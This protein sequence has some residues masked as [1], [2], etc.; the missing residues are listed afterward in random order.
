MT[1]QH[2]VDLVN[3]G[4]KEGESALHLA[5]DLTSDCAHYNRE[6]VK[7]MKLLLDYHADLFLESHVTKETPLHYCAR[8]GNASTLSVVLEYLTAVS[9]HTYEQNQTQKKSGNK[10]EAANDV[11]K[12]SVNATQLRSLNI[13]N[14]AGWS[15]LMVASES[16]HGE[17]VEMLLNHNVRVD[18]FDE[19]G[20]TALHYACARG[21][22]EIADELM[23]H[24]AF[25]NARTRLGVTPLH[26]SAQYGHARLS[27]LLINS[28]NATVDI[29]SLTRKTPMHLA[30]QEGQIDVCQALLDLN[31]DPFAKDME[32]QT[33]LHL[34][35]EKDFS[36][37]VKLFLSYNQDLVNVCNSEGRTC[38]HIAASK[39]SMSVIKGLVKFNPE[40]LVLDK[41]SVSGNTTLHLAAS[42]GFQDIVSLLLDN[43]ANALEEND[44][45]LT[46]LHLAAIF[47]HTNVLEVF[48]G[49]QVSLNY[50]SRESGLTAIHM[51]AHYG[52]TEFVQ[53]LLQD[54]GAQAA[55][56]PPAGLPPA[57]SIGHSDLGGGG[58]QGGGDGGL[59]GGAGMESEGIEYGFTPLHLAAESGWENLVRLLLNSPGVQPD[60][61]T[62]LHGTT[63]LHLAA[64]AGHSNV[65]GLLLSKHEGLLSVYDGRDRSAL[66]MAAA[67]GHRDLC[68]LLV[69]QGADV[70]KK[71]V[72]GWTPLHFAAKA[73]HLDTVEALMENGASGLLETK[74]HKQPICYA[75]AQSHY[76]VLIYLL[77][78]EHNSH[79]LVKDSRF[80]FDMIQCSDSAEDP[81]KVVRYFILWSPAPLEIALKLSAS[82]AEQSVQRKD[83]AKEF[84]LASSFCQTMGVDLTSVTTSIV[85][86]EDVA[87]SLDLHGSSLLDIMIECEQKE[88]VAHA[89]VQKYLSDLWMGHYT[90]APWMI[91]MLLVASLLPPVFFLLSLPIR[92]F[93]L[94]RI[95]LLKMLLY[96]ISHLYFIA[97]LSLTIAFKLDWRTTQDN[98]LIPRWNEW[99]L[100]LFICGLALS[101]I[102]Q[103]S[104][105]NGLSSLKIVV[106]LLGCI[107][108]LIHAAAFAISDY[109]GQ[110]D[111]IYIRNQVLGC[112]LLCCFA[113]L[114]DFL[115]FHHMFGPWAIIISD[116]MKDLFRFMILMGLFILGFT[117]QVS[118]IR[119]PAYPEDFCTSIGRHPLKNPS[120]GQNNTYY[121][122]GR[123][124]VEDF[125]RMAFTLFGLVDYAE[126]IEET[127]CIPIWAETWSFYVYALYNVIALI[128]LINLLIA[129]MSDTYQRIEQQSDIEWKFGR[130]ILIRTMSGKSPAA[131][132][133]NVLVAIFMLIYG[134][135]KHRGKMCSV[136]ELMRDD[137]AGARKGEESGWD[138]AEMGQ[139]GD[140]ATVV[141]AGSG[142]GGGAGALDQEVLSNHTN[143]SIKSRAVGAGGSVGRGTMGK[144]KH[145]GKR[146][147]DDEHYK[148]AVRVEN[149]VDWDVVMNMYKDMQH[150][151]DDALEDNRHQTDHKNYDLGGS[152]SATRAID[153]SFDIQL[154][155]WKT[156]AAASSSEV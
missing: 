128:V 78:R 64:Q 156:A 58:N 147:S 80:I 139:G 35:A 75:A 37:V 143:G 31:A 142:T 70:N 115:T 68:V 63:P 105:L 49:A 84:F 52:Q 60:V 44:E 81:Y 102:L 136:R 149:V 65:I 77:K 3:C 34:A 4:N 39:G 121:V 111:M 15:P 90:V 108:I 19:G 67:N 113:Q 10:G 151:D 50:C 57:Y 126:L 117:L 152:F 14:K 119:Q 85:D 103:P 46:P 42:G 30:A 55:S 66:H 7:L 145:R 6:E 74:D 91:F 23:W 62:S 27:Q 17:V 16:G 101:E 93:T 104:S 43:G 106:I 56:S 71:D 76:E 54:V 9:V 32:E 132:P 5:A 89:S 141:T 155:T 2:A 96:I 116:L 22:T 12:K 120:T 107:S 92:R 125:T 61:H 94:N 110:Y 97:L 135:I 13:R 83:R 40:G 24:K 112:V 41:D 29:L 72:N 79:T 33:P 26:L 154:P 133:V 73:G 47:G 134:L 28:H 8:G 88:V 150:M 129:M 100:V 109:E 122:G 82:Y 140:T 124:V 114:L 11:R 1:T 127:V 153:N 118:T 95:P 87:N 86:T 138:K 137:S 48:K 99:L 18:L 130:A 25:V 69:G 53:E 51:A 98:L 20:N 146:S 38:A 148:M 123:V 131:P 144:K 59:G 21:H 45:G 36:E